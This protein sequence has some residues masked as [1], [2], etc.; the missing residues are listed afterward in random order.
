MNGRSFVIGAQ[1]GQ[2]NY[3]IFSPSS[4]QTFQ[5]NSVR[6]ARGPRVSHPARELETTYDVALNQVLFVFYF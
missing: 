3:K 4:L 2:L 5:R 1:I 6:G